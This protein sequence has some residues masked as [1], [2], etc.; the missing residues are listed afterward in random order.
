[1]ARFIVIHN[2]AA[3]EISQDQLVDL[4]KQVAARLKPGVE[5][6]SSWYASEANKLFCEWEAPN[7]KAIRAALG[8]ALK[9]Y[10]IEAVHSVIYIDP[11]WYAE[12]F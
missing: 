5:W 7:E 8:E 3:E 1:M 12:Q 11:A 10:P 6:I 9:V 4:A 2:V